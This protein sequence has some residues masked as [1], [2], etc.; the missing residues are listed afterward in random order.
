M[1]T[2]FYL[3]K[4]SHLVGISM[5]TVFCFI[6]FLSKK[7]FVREINANRNGFYK[8]KSIHYFDRAEHTVSALWIGDFETDFFL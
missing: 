6:F 8:K 5:E 2:D 4:K 1:E 3:F 7:T